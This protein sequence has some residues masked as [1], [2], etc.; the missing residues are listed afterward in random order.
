[1]RLQGSDET[2]G[3]EPARARVD[4]PGGAFKGPFRAG[5]TLMRRHPIACGR[6]APQ[7]G[8]LGAERSDHGDRGDIARARPDSS[9]RR[10]SRHGDG[11]QGSRA[12][13]GP[14][15]ASGRPDA[16][17]SNTSRNARLLF[18]VRLVASTVA[19]TVRR[20]TFTSVPERNTGLRWIL[21]RVSTAS[22]IAQRQKRRM[23]TSVFG[24]RHV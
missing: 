14:M 6:G 1:R 18:I 8:V 19:F 11:A 5:A 23:P 15:L 21:R 12:E 22:P 3:H 17:R 4:C 2:P 16:A 24:M 20:D 7:A 13:P 9:I 10:N